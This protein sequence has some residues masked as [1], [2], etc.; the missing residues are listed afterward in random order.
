MITEIELNEIQDLIN[1]RNWRVL[2]QKLAPLSPD[3]VGE[4]LTDYSKTD[5]MLLFR[6]LGRE[7]AADTF[8]F[9]D[10]ELQEQLLAEL[11]DQETRDVLANMSPDDRTALLEELPAP[12]TQKLL[13]FLSPD[14]RKEALT[15]LGY[16]EDSVGRLMSPD[17]AA[18]RA[19]LSIPQAMVEIKRQAADS[20]TLNMIY[21]TD[22]NGVLIDDIPLRRFIVAR[23]DQTV[24]DIMD[25]HFVALNA[26][27]PQE[28]AVNAMKQHDYSALP[29]TD[30]NGV[31]LGIVTAD[32]VLEVAIEE[33]TEDFHKGGAIK[34]LDMHYLRAPLKL[35]YVRR[36]SWLVILVFM[37]IF[38][39]A[40]IAYYEE[41]IESIV[42]LVF[43]L[44][45]LIDSGGNAG[46]QAATLVIRSMALGEVRLLDYVKVAWRE[47]RV[48]LLLGLSMSAAVFLVAWW[49]SGIDVAQVVALS[50]TIIVIVGSMVGMSLPF[51]L[52]KVGLDPA[53]A[54]APLVTSVADIAG[55][56]IY[57]AIAS[58][59]LGQLS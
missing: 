27:A 10:D 23:D 2:R 20:E 4:M 29:V 17:F 42:A 6:C 13:N 49:R 24:A 56:L 44:P 38:S 14:D 12:V 30:S 51:I 9:L 21:I 46:S 37:N 39:G 34:P 58:A 25:G 36:I 54:S 50:M 19:D 53:A 47:I 31:L 8:S 43:F 48:A 3:I 18:V 28:E 32:D 52:R 35:L 5:R 41:L 33:D 15:L 57:L 7:Q 40:G 45:L 22:R 59:M 1:G 26:D 55:V 11:T 16:P